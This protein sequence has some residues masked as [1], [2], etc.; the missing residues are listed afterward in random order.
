MCYDFYGVAVHCLTVEHK[1]ITACNSLSSFDSLSPQ[2]HNK[3]LSKVTVTL[4]TR[5][6]SVIPLCVGF[7]HIIQNSFCCQKPIEA[8]SRLVAG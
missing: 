3:V 1:G 7:A 6:C 5:G 8:S 4:S 2:Q